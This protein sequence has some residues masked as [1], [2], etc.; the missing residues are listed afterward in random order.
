MGVGLD[1]VTPAPVA[2]GIR[3]VDYDGAEIIT[4]EGTE[5]G[6][7]LSSHQAETKE[8]DGRC[9]VIAATEIGIDL[10]GEL[11]EQSEPESGPTKIIGNYLGLGRDGLTPLGP[12]QGREV[13]IY[14]QT[15]STGN[16]GPR[17]WRAPMPPPRFPKPVSC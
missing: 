10:T 8:C 14:A 5:I 1:G 4:A 3:V 11:G 9:N 17:G 6:G 16:R 13:G 7:V 15:F 12:S 2:V